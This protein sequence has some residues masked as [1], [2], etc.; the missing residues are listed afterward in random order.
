MEGLGEGATKEDARDAS[1]LSRYFYDVAAFRG[2]LGKEGSLFVG[3]IPLR[4]TVERFYIAQR[5][6]TRVSWAISR[7]F[8]AA[9]T[10]QTD[11]GPEIPDRMITSPR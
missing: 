8:E 4:N 5:P 6:T 2:S 1:L 3:R 7:L 9:A 11:L 10:R